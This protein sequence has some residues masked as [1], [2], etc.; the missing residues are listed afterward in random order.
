MPLL[1]D[2][3]S[4]A[5]TGP[6]YGSTR[7]T[8][9]DLF[10]RDSGVRERLRPDLVIRLGAAPTSASL[11]RWL[12]E[13]DEALQ[14]VVD[15]GARWK[16]HQNTASLYV[17]ADGAATL[18]SLLPRVGPP[19]PVG[20]RRRWETAD[21]AANAAACRAPGPH[22]EGH[23]AAAVM[24]AVAAEDA[25][26]VSSSMPIRDVDAYGGS[27][28]DGLVLFG[29]RGASGI[30]GIV[31]TAAGV[32]AGIGRRT[33]VLLGDLAL[34]HDSN[35]LLAAREEGVEL[36]LVVVNNDGGG[37]FHMLPIRELDPPFTRLFATPHGLDLSHLARLYGLSFTRVERLEE[38]GEVLRDEL[39]GAGSRMIEVV[40]DRED[41]RRG[42]QAAATA[43]GRAAL[44]ALLTYEEGNGP[45]TDD[46]STER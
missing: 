1:A 19:A 32:A 45:G 42:H 3:L 34:L 4:G 41:N 29:N 27:R 40:S 26:F 13:S 35:G 22:H 11:L 23:V 6:S 2:P 5:R 39:A 28:E 36:V 37:I 12:A 21:R 16:D 33:V 44:D 38:A 30:D 15:D 17:A 18:E 46:D 8:T 25:L 43:A 14:V 10:L 9:Y 7:I 20:W 24:G 31:S